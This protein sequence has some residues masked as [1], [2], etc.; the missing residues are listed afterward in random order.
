MAKTCIQISPSKTNSIQFHNCTTQFHNDYQNSTNQVGLT[1]SILKAQV[2]HE[3]LMGALCNI[4]L[5]TK[6]TNLWIYIAA[7]LS[8][9]SF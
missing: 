7:I 1:L 9:K 6:E 8:L 5:A 3:S 4:C 2:T